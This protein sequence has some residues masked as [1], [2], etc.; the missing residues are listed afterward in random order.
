MFSSRFIT[1][2]HDFSSIQTQGVLINLRERILTRENPTRSQKLQ[3]KDAK[4]PRA[5]MSSQ[6]LE[7]DRVSN[8]VAAREL[9]SEDVRELEDD[10]G[11]QSNRPGVRQLEGDDAREADGW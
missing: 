4:R 2:H 6:E 10:P 1:H 9:D 5:E 8:E 11:R 3:G 7:M